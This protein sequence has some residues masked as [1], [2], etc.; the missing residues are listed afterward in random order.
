MADKKT[1][2][3]LILDNISDSVSNLLYYNRKEDDNLTIKKLNKA[4]KDGEITIDEMV[5]EFRKHLENSFKK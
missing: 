3:Q 2:K 4:I 5:A 1:T